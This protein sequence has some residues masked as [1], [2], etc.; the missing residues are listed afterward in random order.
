M[1]H[2]RLGNFAAIYAGAYGFVDFVAF[3]TS[4][5]ELMKD[6]GAWYA[7][8]A[9]PMFAGVCLFAASVR[10][11]ARRLLQVG[12]VSH[13]LVAP[14]VYYSML[15]L[16]VFIP[17]LSYLWWRAYVVARNDEVRPTSP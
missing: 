8:L 2:Q 16:G 14:A 7:M 9:P 11:T 15:M 1:I 17:V 10:M 4:G 3:V 13:I 5:S 6:A 12:I